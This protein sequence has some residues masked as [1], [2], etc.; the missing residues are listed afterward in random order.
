MLSVNKEDLKN[1][2]INRLKA[3]H[4]L[5]FQAAK[6]AHEAATHEDNIPDNKYETLALE[7]SYI[8]QG[9]ANRAQEIARSVQVFEQL[10]L[11]EFNDDSEVRLSALVQLL[12]EAEKEKW[13]FLAPMS[14]GLAIDFEGR[15]V[16]LITPASPLG[17]GL[18][19]SCCGDLVEVGSKGYEIQKI[20]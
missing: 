10:V 11:Q 9:Q 8:A 20:Y 18:I 4:A 13:V 16:L 14:G 17:R 3:D 12:D 2:I 19:G 6:T 5:L 15:E 7:A 1:T